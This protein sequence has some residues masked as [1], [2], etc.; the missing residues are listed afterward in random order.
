MTRRNDK[1]NAGRIEEEKIIAWCSYCKDPIY[2]DDDFHKQ[3]GS[4]YHTDCWKQEH[5]IV[6]ELK[7]D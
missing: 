2:E 1:P 3:N 5:D 4:M 7:F 6:E